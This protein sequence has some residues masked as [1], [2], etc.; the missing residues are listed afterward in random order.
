MPYDPELVERIRPE[1]ERLPFVEEKKMFG[2]IG[3]I[4]AGNM[5]AGAHHDGRLVIRCRRE[6]YDSLLRQPGANPMEH[7]GRRLVGWVLVDAEAISEDADLQRWVS[8]GTDF[9]RSLPSK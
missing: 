8:I 6:E 5:A 7:G 9:A 1:L 4:I 3:W 2:G